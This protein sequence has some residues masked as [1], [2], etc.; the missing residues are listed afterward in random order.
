[1]V[2]STKLLVLFIFIIQC[3][4]FHNNIYGW[5]KFYSLSSDEFVQVNDLDKN[6]HALKRV[7]NFS[8]KNI[9]YVDFTVK[10]G[11]FILKGKV[12]IKL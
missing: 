6:L 10:I 4:S 8:L 9:E 3:Y 1:M 11:F 12:D 2:F 7:I 5:R